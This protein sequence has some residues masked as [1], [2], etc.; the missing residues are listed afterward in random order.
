MFKSKKALLISISAV[1]ML[2]IISFVFLYSDF[3]NS[4]LPLFSRWHEQ[5]F[6]QDE[7]YQHLKE[8]DYLG[9][10]VIQ[11]TT[12]DPWIDVFL[13]SS[14]PGNLLLINIEELS[15]DGNL[16]GGTSAQIFFAL[17]GYDH[18]SANSVLI[19]LRTG[20]NTIDLPHG[21]YERLRLDLAEEVRVSMIVND[22][23]L[24]S[25]SVFSIMWTSLI[26]LMVSSVIFVLAVNLLI[27]E[28][29]KEHCQ[30]NREDSDGQE[31]QSN[32]LS[33]SKPVRILYYFASL[34]MPNIFLVF[35]YNQNR[36]LNFLPFM[37]L[38]VWIAIFSVAGL[39]LFLLVR[40][41]VR[42]FEI[43]LIIIAAFWM[44][45]WLF[46]SI[47]S[48]IANHVV[49]ET[50][51][52][53]LV[54]QLS[55]LLIIIW[56]T[57]KV[58]P[59]LEKMNVVFNTMA[60]TI[61]VLFLFNLY[62]GLRDEIMFGGGQLNV[63]EAAT[64]KTDFFVDESVPNPDIYWFHVD[65]MMSLEVT[66]DFF[67]ISLDNER[68]E[69][70]RRGFAINYGA[71]HNV[72]NTESAL[73]S[74]FSPWFYDDFYGQTL[75]ALDNTPNIIA[76]PN[77][78]TVLVN[79]LA[80]N[81]LTLYDVNQNNETFKAF[82]SA[83]YRIVVNAD[84]GWFNHIPFHVLYN[85]Y[86]QTPTDQP[87]GIPIDSVEPSALGRIFGE[88]FARLLSM[89][90]PLT[91]ILDPDAISREDV[92][93]FPIPD[94]SNRLP[95]YV[96]ESERQLYANLIDSLNIAE[97][98]FSFTT[99]MDLHLSRWSTPNKYY[100]YH[101]GFH[102]AFTVMLNAIDIVLSENPNAIIV[103]QADHGIHGPSSQ[104]AMYEAGHSLETL[105]TLQRSV[106]SAVRIPEKYGGL[107]ASL[108]PRNIARELVNR[109]VGQN[110][111]LLPQD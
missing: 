33:M 46:G 4:D 12:S 50:Y 52:L 89:T 91:P 84:T 44:G 27:A 41:I 17:P 76:S 59:H 93:F 108:D 107:D 47:F 69:L 65:G 103:L 102:D 71:R 38:L 63:E 75:A 73:P 32:V 13:D 78:F 36:L 35:F 54:A 6:S 29:R 22:A 95:A 92:N 85:W 58:R 109:F 3:T 66:E 18:A 80:E 62:P 87:L 99:F 83:G 64:F 68:Y 42:E 14:L 70:E 15:L 28:K 55:F 67:G 111:E 106:F 110:Y 57:I 104:S 2:F 49:V 97:P 23:T 48:A 9:N 31:S 40:L 53:L 51:V 8:F 21:Y 7:M 79:T 1:L 61:C 90:T 37:H 43:R 88:D 19:T 10:G 86:N 60:L 105:A 16:I 100:S 72:I 26:V 20:T 56:M 34:L 11:S 81:G 45:F 101:Q 94:H 30:K 39:G 77:A 5:Q 82:M 96:S 74:L 98:K 25:N 24:K